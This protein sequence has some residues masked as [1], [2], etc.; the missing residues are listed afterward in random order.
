MDDILL[1]GIFL[2]LL[3]VIY[4]LVG[5]FGSTKE[6]VASRSVAHVRREGVGLSTWPKPIIAAGNKCLQSSKTYVPLRRFPT[7]GATSLAQLGEAVDNLS[8]QASVVAA[9]ADQISDRKLGLTEQKLKEEH[10]AAVEAVVH[11][12]ERKRIKDAELF[13]DKFA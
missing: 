3:N 2:T 6:A 10:E 9:R 4:A 5:Y 7:Q 1:L 11:A 8:H 13:A 12:N